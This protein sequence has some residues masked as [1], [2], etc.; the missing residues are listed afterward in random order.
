[1]ITHNCEDGKYMITIMILCHNSVQEV[2][3]DHMFKWYNWDHYLVI[4]I[5]EPPRGQL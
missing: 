3:Y 2:N 5:A 1:M 4:T